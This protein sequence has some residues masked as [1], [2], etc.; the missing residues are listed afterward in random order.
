MAKTSLV[1]PDIDIGCEIV[2][3]LEKSKIK[4]VVA[5]WLLSDEFSDWKLVISSPSFQRV[6]I[7]GAYLEMRKAIENA[8]IPY[9]KTPPIT[10]MRTTDPFVKTLRA[11][12]GH[13]AS[14]LGMRLGGQRIGDRYVEDAYVYKIT[15]P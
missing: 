5:L 14:V 13:T 15:S 9:E 12:F 4:V 10:A 7:H 2:K 1:A 11:L 8:G 6:G 3:A